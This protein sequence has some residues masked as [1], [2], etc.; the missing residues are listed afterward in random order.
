MKKCQLLIIDDSE[1]IQDVIADRSSD[2][3]SR[4]RYR[5]TSSKRASKCTMRIQTD[6]HVWK[7]FSDIEASKGDHSASTHVLLMHPESHTYSN[8]LYITH[9]SITH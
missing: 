1:D 8:P 5:A 9:I 6:A 4:E 7:R 2:V 3:Q